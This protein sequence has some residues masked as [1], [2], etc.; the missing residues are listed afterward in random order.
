MTNDIAKQF[1]TISSFLPVSKELEATSHSK[2]AINM[3]GSTGKNSGE[4]DGVYVYQDMKGDKPFYKNLVNQSYLYQT[5]GF[6]YVS[7]KDDF[8]A[9]K[10]TG[11]CRS[12]EAGLVNPSRAHL[13]KM[14]RGLKTKWVDQPSVKVATMV[15][16]LS[17]VH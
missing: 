15:L 2:L 13:W 9:G 11:W 5:N 14:W 10:A 17:H 8:D 12:A 6:W 7:G 16:S 1:E 4:V 3:S